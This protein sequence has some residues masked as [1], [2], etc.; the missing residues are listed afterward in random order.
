[1]KF[2]AIAADDWDA[3]VLW[4]AGQSLEATTTNRAQEDLKAVRLK[5]DDVARLLPVVFQNRLLGELV[6][7]RR[8]APLKA[9]QHPL[10]QFDYGGIT[11]LSGRPMHRLTIHSKITEG[12]KETRFSTRFLFDETGENVVV[13]N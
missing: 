12:R 8:L 9:D 4:T 7:R 6:K 5:D 2:D 13:M 3:L 1:M 11:N 10:V